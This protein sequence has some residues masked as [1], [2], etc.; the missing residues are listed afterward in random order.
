MGVEEAADD[1]EKEESVKR[2][3]ISPVKRKTGGITELW[4]RITDESNAQSACGG[5]YGAC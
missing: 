1:T 5:S 4:I 2:A 3:L